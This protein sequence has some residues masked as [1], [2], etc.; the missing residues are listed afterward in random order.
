MEADETWKSLERLTT[1]DPNPGQICAPCS[2]AVSWPGKVCTASPPLSPPCAAQIS[3]NKYQWLNIRIYHSLFWEKYLKHWSFFRLPR[4]PG[5]LDLWKAEIECVPNFPV[6]QLDSCC[7]FV[8][9]PFRSELWYTIINETLNS[10][11]HYF[12]IWTRLLEKYVWK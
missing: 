2:T 11:L 3:R 8:D 1:T 9:P 5:G 12:A 10:L 7:V 4:S 6:G